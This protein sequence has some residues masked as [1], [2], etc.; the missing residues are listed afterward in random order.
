MKK[1]PY[2]GWNYIGDTQLDFHGYG[3]GEIE[4][5][6]I[7]DTDIDV[8]EMFHSLGVWDKVEEAGDE[9]YYYYTSGT[10]RR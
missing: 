7:S 4:E 1:A 6:Y 10:T 2:M 8:S 5:V 9:A 3:R